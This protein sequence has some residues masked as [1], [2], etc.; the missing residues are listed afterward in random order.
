MTKRG[1]IFTLLCFGL[2][3]EKRDDY[4]MSPYKEVM[5]DAK[6]APY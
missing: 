4:N 6:N 2:R 5:T 1:F 3:D